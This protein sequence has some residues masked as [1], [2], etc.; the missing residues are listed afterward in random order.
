MK[1]TGYCARCH[2]VKLV[3]CSANG[4]VMLASGNIVQ[5]LC[6]ACYEAEERRR[7]ERQ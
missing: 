3:N 2:K 6:D 1:L 5:G 7:K 4:M